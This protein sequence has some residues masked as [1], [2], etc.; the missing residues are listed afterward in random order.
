MIHRMSFRIVGSVNGSP[1]IMRLY[2]DCVDIAINGHHKQF[3]DQEGATLY[4]QQLKRNKY[5]ERKQHDFIR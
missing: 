3:P 1:I 5:R 2:P 4:L